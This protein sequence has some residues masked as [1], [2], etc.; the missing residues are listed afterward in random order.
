MTVNRSPALMGPPAAP[1]SA[2]SKTEY[3][4]DRPGDAPGSANRHDVLCGRQYGGGRP[5]GELPGR[6]HG[7]AGCSTTFDSAVVGMAT[8]GNH[9]YWEV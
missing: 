5:P 6:A 1:P 2:R 7:T 8:A 3:S 9:G 4:V